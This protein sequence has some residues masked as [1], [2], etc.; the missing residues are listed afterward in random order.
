MKNVRTFVVIPSLPELLEP[1][2]QIAYNLWWTWTPAA[3]DLFR[4]LDPDLWMA[5]NHNPIALLWRASQERLQQAAEDKAYV[6]QL[7]RVADQFY[8][9]RHSRTWFDEQHPDQ[10]DQTIAYFSA[11]FGLHECLPIYSGGL[12]VLAGDHLKSASDLGAPLVG[13]G[14][15]YRNGYFQQQLTDDGWQIEHF[16]A[17]DFDQWPAEL[18]RDEEDRAVQIGVPIGNQTLKAQIWRVHVGRVELYL[19]DADIIENPPELRAITSRLYGGDKDMRIRQEIL[20]GVGGYRALRA[21]GKTPT[22]CHMNEGHAA[23]LALE[24]VRQA[25]EEH[26]LT[27]QQAFEAVSGGN[28]FTTHTPVPAGIDRFDPSLVERYMGWMAK[29]MGIS[30]KQ[31]IQLGRES[32]EEVGD[33]CM[34]VIAL[35]MSHRSNGVSQLHG[36]VSRDMWQHVW[37]EI[38]REEVPVS[39]ITNGVHTQ[40]W[41]SAE[42]ADLLNQYLGPTWSEDPDSQE[43]WSRVEH[44][45]DAELWRVHERRRERLV[46]NIRRR[47][48][49]QL[50]RRGAP[51]AELRFADEAL[52]P[53]AITIGFARRFAPYKRATLLF[54]NIERLRALISNKQRPIQFIF[55]GKAH[56][57]DSAGKE[58]IKAVSAI[59]SRPEFRRHL[60]FIENYD[61]G[62]ARLMVRGVDVWLNN[63]LRPH[64]A[65]GTSGMKLGP[66]GGLNLSCLDGWWPEAYNGENGW[67]IGDGQPYE[68]L[69]YQ[70]HVESESL[71]NL[72][73]R[74]VVPLFYDRAADGIPRRWLERMK[75]S[76]RTV[77]PM[78]T[79]HRMVK[80]YINDFYSPAVRRFQ[81][82]TDD[83]F[84]LAKRLSDWKNSLRTR[85]P[86]V[87]IT[88]VWTETNQNTLKVGD[89]LPIKAKVNLGGV[90]PADIQVEAYF[91]NVTVDGEIV[92]GSRAP[93][94]YV[95]AESNGEHV[96][97][98]LVPCETSGRYGYAVRVVPHNQ[99]LAD[100]YTQGMIVWG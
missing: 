45:P 17:Y 15:M 16:P 49:E 53:E 43:T 32:T 74:E 46:A 33:F 100:Q 62:L 73:E 14:L 91:G 69:G 18:A 96:F 11:E 38:R 25:M 48:R 37:P 19:L 52:D 93:M 85:W 40:S 20:L 88:H 82:L 84:T 6:A 41:I 51:P 22:V 63:P 44:I 8:I 67:A 70:D 10:R 13:V 60:V 1:L 79:T 59:A 75:N 2:R 76:M 86:G 77:S 66:N 68:D 87:Q 26:G 3:I 92:N 57:A 28:V 29:A 94:S 21:L 58:L 98:G 89:E 23:F 80:Q 54:R 97:E 83:D 78:Y 35:R 27:Y 95:A 24:R 56:P 42:M 4:R 99:D 47:I 36:T 71:Y 61:M 65:S 12:G 31:L 50:R 72:L 81:A 30:S 9:Y 64:E 55:A 39:H 90:A 5:V 34:P 7:S